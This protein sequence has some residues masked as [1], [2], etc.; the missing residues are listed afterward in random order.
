MAAQ[1]T[2]QRGRET[3]L[4]TPDTRI[5]QALIDALAARGFDP[6]HVATGADARD[7]VLA[8][9]PEGA[10]VAH[11]GSATLGQ[12]GLITALHE[13]TRI[14]YGNP[15]WLAEDDAAQRRL[16]RTQ[17]C[18]T[19]DVFLGSVQ[20]VSRDGRVLGADQSG[21]R[22]AFYLYGPARVIWVVGANKIVADLDA[23]LRRLYE[24]AVPREDARVKAAGLSGSV[25]YKIAIIDGESVPGRITIVLVDEDLGY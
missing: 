19:A 1:P 23:A 11:G 7:L 6:R 13:S 22:Q 2:I 21:S 10:L 3:P 25:P 16:I 24:V 8:E 17:V 18:A 20:A 15:I 4:P 5:D 12:I 14:R 9:L